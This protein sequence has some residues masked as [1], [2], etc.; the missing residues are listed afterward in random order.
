LTGLQVAFIGGSLVAKNRQSILVAIFTICLAR[1]NRCYA[2]TTASAAVAGRAPSPLCFAPLAAMH[3]AAGSHPTRR[4]YQHNILLSVPPDR[5]A[6][7]TTVNTGGGTTSCIHPI[8]VTSTCQGSIPFAPFAGGGYTLVAA[9]VLTTRSSSCTAVWCGVMC[10][11]SV[12]ITSAR[13]P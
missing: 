4:H 3:T 2:C 6:A 7:G 9:A 8:I 12:N 11:V 5:H 13:I 10:V 1:F